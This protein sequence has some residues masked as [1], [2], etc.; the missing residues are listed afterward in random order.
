MPEIDLKDNLVAPLYHWM[1]S[2]GLEQCWLD[3]LVLGVGTLM[4]G[5]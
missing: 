4:D 5:K 3:I 1:Q 2:L